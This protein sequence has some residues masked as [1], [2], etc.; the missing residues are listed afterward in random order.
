MNNTVKRTI[1]GVG[2]IAAML[3]GLLVNKFLFAILF[4][5]IMITMMMEFYRMT[6]GDNYKFARA[7]AIF[8][9]VI[10]FVLIFLVSAYG[11]RVDFVGMALV[12]IIIVMIFSL[13]SKNKTEFWKFS[14]MYTGFLYIAVPLALSNFIAFKHGEFSGTLLLSFF[15]IIWASDV[16]AFIFGSAFGQKYGKKLFPEISPKKSWIGFW[17]GMLCAIIASVILKLTGMF[18]FPMIHCVFLAIVMDIAGVYGDLFESQWKRCYDLKDS[19]NIIPG[20]GGMLDR[21]D[22]TLMAFPIGVLYM[23]L[24][25]LI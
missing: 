11:M 23:V 24:F 1:S 12:P 10:L 18:E 14:H 7:M 9:G 21:F 16:G 3:L 4:L 5:F 20:H 19:G 13:Y 8:A 2:F 15:I 25:N 6:M 22:S 17:G